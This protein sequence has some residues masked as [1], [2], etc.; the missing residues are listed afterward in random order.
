MPLR[1]LGYAMQ[2][3]MTE[4]QAWAANPGRILDLF[5]WKREYDDEQHG[6]KRRR[7]GGDD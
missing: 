3:G 5:L 1:L 4:P 7:Q 6:I 2:V